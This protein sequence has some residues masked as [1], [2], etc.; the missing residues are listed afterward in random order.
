M[1]NIKER[2]KRIKREIFS[3]I[4]KILIFYLALFYV[5]VKSI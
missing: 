5:K 3:F 4:Y 2:I 1:L